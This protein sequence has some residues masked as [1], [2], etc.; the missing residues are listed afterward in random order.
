MTKKKSPQKSTEANKSDVA[1]ASAADHDRPL[2]VGVGASAGGLEA[3]R[4]L[5]KGLPDAP[6]FA[7]AS[8][9]PCAS[10]CWCSTIN[11]A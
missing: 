3:F 7:K 4:E 8:S 2:V 10:R 11:Y 1:E 5:L 6:V 9:R